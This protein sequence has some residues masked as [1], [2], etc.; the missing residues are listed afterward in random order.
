[1]PSDNRR[2]HGHRNDDRIFISRLLH[3]V[4]S[5]P[6]LIARPF[7]K[8]DVMFR[9]QIKRSGLP[10]SDAPGSAQPRDVP[11]RFSKERCFEPPFMSPEG[12]R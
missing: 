12:W 11:G 10:K 8:H 2:T 1:M 9:G 4:L 5:F 6:Q 7:L 3:E